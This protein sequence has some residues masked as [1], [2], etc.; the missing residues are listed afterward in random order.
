MNI[1]KDSA[2]HPAELSAVLVPWPVHIPER[3]EPLALAIIV[4]DAVPSK[5]VHRTEIVGLGLCTEFPH[6][7][8]SRLFYPRFD[9]SPTNLRTNLILASKKNPPPQLPLQMYTPRQTPPPKSRYIPCQSPHQSRFLA[10]PPP[11][12]CFPPT[13]PLPMR[14]P[15]LQESPPAATVPN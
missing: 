11:I 10:S 5:V 2:N 1:G 7:F 13:I 12:H 4:V 9:I 3:E 6:H 14:F 15:P 8:P